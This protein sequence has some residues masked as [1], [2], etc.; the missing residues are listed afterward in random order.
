MIEPCAV[1]TVPIL[2]STE[3]PTA[4]TPAMVGADCTSEKKILPVSVTS[5]FVLN[6]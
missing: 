6:F 5:I 3:M 1:I 2:N 4:P